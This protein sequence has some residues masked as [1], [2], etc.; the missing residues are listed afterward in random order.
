MERFLTAAG[1]AL[2]VRDSGGVEGAPVFVLLHGYLENLEAW[3]EV[4]ALLKKHARVISIDIPGHGLSE[5]KGEVHAME[6]L[7]AVLKGVLDTLDVNRAFVVGHSMGGYVALEYLSHYPEG[8]AG[9][10]LLH[11]TPNPDTEEK[12][13]QRVREIEVIRSGHKDMLVS[14]VENAFAALSRKKMP[15]AVEQVR[16]MAELNDGDGIA[17]LLGGMM[18]R[19]DHNDTLRTSDVPQLLIFGRGDE[20]LIPE[21][22]QQIV[23]AHPQAEVVWLENSGHMGLLE[24]P[25]AVADI[26]LAFSDK[27]H[28]KKL[29]KNI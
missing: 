21:A 8:V 13:R 1:V 17:A 14:S 18:E 26:L 28:S 4:A 10:V 3:D 2:R 22:A 20:Y 6:M 12:R 7:A 25:P 16:V 23:E 27:H 29:S 19:R 5:V 11:S 15:D 24:E 9:L